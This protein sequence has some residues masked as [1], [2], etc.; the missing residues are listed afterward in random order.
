MSFRSTDDI[1]LPPSGEVLPRTKLKLGTFVPIVIALLGVG[2]VLFGGL[3]AHD[4]PPST[5]GQAQ[6]P[7]VV[8][9]VQTGSI[10]Q[11]DDSDKIRKML[12]MLDR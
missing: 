4:G 8:D 5:I 1:M 12:E 3:R 2:A 6:P 7:A 11:P 9:P 10:A